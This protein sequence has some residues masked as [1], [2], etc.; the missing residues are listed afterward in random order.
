M[1]VQMFRHFGA[2]HAPTKVK[3]Q[4]E[5]KQT[6]Q[7]TVLG[8]ATILPVTL[9]RR[10]ERTGKLKLTLRVCVNKR[11]FPPS[12]SPI[13]DAGHFPPAGKSAHVVVD[14]NVSSC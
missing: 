11:R 1:F 5:E 13:F 12:D 2:L 4:A 14:T 10:M 8:Q 6:T 9:D 7:I 3:T